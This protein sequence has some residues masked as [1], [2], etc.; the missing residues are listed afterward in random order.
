MKNIKEVFKPLLFALVSAT[1]V[2]CD[3]KD[4]DELRRLERE[5]QNQKVN[6]LLQS[7]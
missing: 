7:K 4:D 5:R 2:C 6:T 3:C 1:A